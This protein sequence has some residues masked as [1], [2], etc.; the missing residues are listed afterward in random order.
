M[1][2]NRSDPTHEDRRSATGCSGPRHQREQTATPPEVAVQGL[3]TE[4]PYDCSEQQCA[5]EMKHDDEH[6]VWPIG[7]NPP[8][9]PHRAVH[10]RMGNVIGCTLP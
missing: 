4:A 10:G 3:H 1:R 9:V 2:P 5:C 7:V 8:D 6:L